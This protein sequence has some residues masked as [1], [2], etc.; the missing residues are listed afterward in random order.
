MSA[1]AQDPWGLAPVG[2]PSAKMRTNDDSGEHRGMHER[3]L[4]PE[5]LS[6]MSGM[7]SH[8]DAISFSWMTKTLLLILVAS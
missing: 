2:E 1:A 5:S 8:A 4:V 7:T 3:E 6:V